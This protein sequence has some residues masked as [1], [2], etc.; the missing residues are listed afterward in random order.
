MLFE[1]GVKVTSEHLLGQ[2][3]QQI[4][5]V[6]KEEKKKKQ[7]QQPKAYPLLSKQIFFNIST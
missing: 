3:S 4:F 7:Q 2:D 1:G 5:G 6:W